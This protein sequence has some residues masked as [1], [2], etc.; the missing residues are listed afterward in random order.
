MKSFI[1]YVSRERK[2]FDYPPF[3]ELA[4]I[5]IHDEQ[6]KKVEDI[7]RKLVNKIGIIKKDTTF[8]AFDTDLYEKSHGEWQQKIILKDKSLNYLISQL[9]IEIIRN[10][11]ITLEWN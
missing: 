8:F 10:R 2:D 4:T 9:E 5:R 1:S 6:K 11:S 3:S 7:M